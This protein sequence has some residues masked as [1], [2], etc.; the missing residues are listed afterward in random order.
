MSRRHSHPY[1]AEPEPAED[2][3]DSE[4]EDDEDEQAELSVEEQPKP[5]GQDAPE[6]VEDASKIGAQRLRRP[7]LGDAITS[8]TGG[9]S[10]GFGAVAFAAGAAAVG[11][12]LGSPSVGL[13]VGS[14][15]FPIGFLI[16]LVG[17]T[18]LF[19]E[20]FLLPVAAVIKERG[21]LVQ[22]GSLWSVTLGAN[23]LGALAFAVLI[24]WDGVLAESVADQLVI[25]A[26]HK[27]AYVLPTAFIK[28]IFAGW[29][30][31]TLTWLLVASAGGMGPRIAVIWGI[32]ALIVLGQFNHVIISAAEIFAAMMLDAN[33]TIG[34]WFTDNFLPALTGNVLGGL[35]FET[36]LQTVQARYQEPDEEEQPQNA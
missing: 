8:F 24:S 27:V 29:L 1:T 18:E 2:L 31:T 9:M 30:M 3:R 19:T 21:N 14:L 10:V 36:M 33:I 35:I 6:V 22:L 7:L 5:L 25:L 23:L 17:K 16:L 15:L 4:V 34:M 26:E 13:L 32:A 28:A 20:N 12:T 11:G